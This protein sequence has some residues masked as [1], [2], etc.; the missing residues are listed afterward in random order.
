[1]RF[2]LLESED[3]DSG[4]LVNCDSL[5]HRRAEDIFDTSASGQRTGEYDKTASIQVRRPI[6]EVIPRRE[7][8]LSQRIQL[9][10]KTSTSTGYVDVAHPI[11]SSVLHGIGEW[12]SWETDVMEST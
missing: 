10:E 11:S 7:E 9:I 4:W 12:S 8:S 2:V 3:P 1:M 5:L 6:V